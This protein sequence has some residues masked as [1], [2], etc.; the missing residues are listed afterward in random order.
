M[1]ISCENI[2]REYLDRL[3]GEFSCH[4][5]DSRLRLVTPYVYPDNDFIE[6]YV[7]QLPDGR[8]RVTDLGEATRHLHTQGFDLFASP[9]RKF[10]AETA[11]SRVDA[12]LENGTIYKVG[13]PE[14][15]ATMLLD[16]V[17]AS[18]GVSDLIYTSRAYEPAPFID[19]VAEF[20]RQEQIP[21]ERRV[22]VRGESGREYKIPF[23]IRSVYLNP[24]SAEFQRSLK[25]R[26]DATVRMW[27]DVDRVAKKYTLL[28]D[29][30]FSWPEPDVILLS[31]LSSVFRWSARR[32]L[33]DALHQVA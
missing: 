11:V 3:K 8:V 28:N 27:V 20:L 5:T 2:V 4:R 32:E 23:K 6:L 24:L 10:I 15:V 9:K 1:Q 25:P 21:F 13:P 14:E 12:I 18:R 30:D 16:L 19:E 22:R 33:A 26:V 7:E 17:I 31:R 29:V